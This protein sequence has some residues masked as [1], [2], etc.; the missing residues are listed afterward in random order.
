MFKVSKGLVSAGVTVLAMGL[1]FAGKSQLAAYFNDPGTVDNIV[2]LIGTVGSLV[3]GI[4]EGVKGKQV[5]EVQ[6]P[7]V[8][9]ADA[10]ASLSGGNA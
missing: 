6:A 10:V 5:V 4:L 1:T 8:S 2:L 7:A 3:S 9:R